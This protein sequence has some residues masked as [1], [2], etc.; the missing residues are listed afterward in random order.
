MIAE[1]SCPHCG[2]WSVELM[3]DGADFC[4]D[5]LTASYDCTCRK[6]GWTWRYHEFYE[7]VEARNEP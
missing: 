3:Y 6:C 7:L 2:D 1:P 5:T 4:G